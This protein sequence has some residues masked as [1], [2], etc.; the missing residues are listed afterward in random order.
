MFKNFYDIAIE[1][2]GTASVAFHLAVLNGK[3]VSD[4]IPRSFKL[5]LP[6]SIEGANL[7]VKQ[8]YIRI[9]HSPATGTNVGDL[10]LFPGGI[11]VMIVNKSFKVG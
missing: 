7:K 6:E 1:Y 2:Y 11:G 5:L 8:E 4:N 10:K 9:D 3:S